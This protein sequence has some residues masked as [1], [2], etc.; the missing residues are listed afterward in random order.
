VARALVLAALAAAAPAPDAAAQATRVRVGWP[1]PTI[2]AAAAPFAAAVRMGWFAAEGLELDLVPLAG[3]VDGVKHVA[4]RTVDFALASPEA[5]AAARAEGLRARTFYVAYQGNVF[6]LAVP[7]ESP[8]RSVADLRGRTIGVLSLGSSGVLVARA[9]AAA[10]G[11]DPERD[12]RLA[13]VG[14]GA[15]AA[16]LL[17]S[18]QVDVLSLSDVQLALVEQAGVPLR[19]LDTPEIR[20]FPSDG[21]VAVDETLATR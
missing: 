3:S 7:V 19:R 18:R 17:R 2:S 21:F 5:V 13:A 10:H 20:R 16:A 1:A 12:L 4:T 8:I 15:Q 9:L 14:Q 11:L 6:G